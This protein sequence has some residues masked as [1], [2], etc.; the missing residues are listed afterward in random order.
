[1]K[2]SVLALSVLVMLASSQ[3]RIAWYGEKEFEGNITS[4]EQEGYTVKY[5]ESIDEKTL[6]RY[7]VLVLCLTEPSDQE[8]GVILDFLE[9]GG[10]LLILYNAMTHDNIEDVLSAYQLERAAEA[11]SNIVFPFLPEDKIDELKKRISISQQG[12]GRILA[13]GYDPL[14][15]QAV[16]LLF[17]VDSLLKFGMDWLCQDWHVEQ[18]QREVTRTRFSIMVLLGV[19]AATLVIG[20]FLYRKKMS[21]APESSESK[22]SQKAEKI[23]EL[24]ARFVYGEVSRDEYKKELKKLERSQ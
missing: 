13:V 4:L 19:A 17:D 5:I 15:F 8:K 12:K 21:G 3:G 16:S 10:G 1:M 23:R 7:D 22:E 18:T 9:A 11:D 20:Y 6:S 2:K 14:T 24:K